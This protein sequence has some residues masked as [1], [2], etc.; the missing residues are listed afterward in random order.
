MTDEMRELNLTTIAGLRKLIASGAISQADIRKA[1]RARLEENKD[2]NAF[3]TLMIDDHSDADVS[4]PL[5]GIPVGIKD[6]FD[7]AGVRTTAGF[8]HFEHR[9]PTRDA[10]LVTRLK[11]AGAVIVGKTNMHRLGMGTTSLDSHFGPVRN[12]VAPDRV[13]G[14]SSGGSAA[15]VASDLCYATIDTDAVGS[16]RL[17]AACCSVT[18]FKPSFGV[19]S[20][21]GILEG[22]PVDPVILALSHA[23]II[24]RSAADVETVFAILA[25]EPLAAARRYPRLGVARNFEASAEIRSSFDDAAPRIARLA[26][27]SATV[28]IPFAEARFD[29]TGIPAARD[30]INKRLFSDVDLVILPTLTNVAPLIEDATKAGDQAV[31]SANTFF[32]NY[33]GL[34]AVTIPVV[35]GPGGE[36]LA[37]QIV[38]PRGGDLTVLAFAR[39]VQEGLSP[40][41]SDGHQTPALP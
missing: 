22:E 2:L 25:D 10:V 14:G 29:P 7:T 31:S 11:A 41:W 23:A 5:A 38:G 39:K 19:L 34:P 27:S 40:Q 24:A 32:A 30:Q 16:A 26:R 28:E 4:L 20:Q 12:P 3:I 36:A 33:F 6:F 8:V 35:S 21:E 17:P 1:I 18:G 37:V 13:A 9:V 15:A